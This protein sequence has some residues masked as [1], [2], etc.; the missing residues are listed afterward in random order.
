MDISNTSH[1][2][3]VLAAL[4]MLPAFFQLHA[5]E[6]AE[7]GLYLPTVD[8]AGM[9]MSKQVVSMEESRYQHVVRQHT[10]YS[11]GAASLATILKYGYGMDVDEASVMQGLLNVSD[12]QIVMSKG[13]SLLD[14]KNYAE[15]LGFRARGYR[16]TLDRLRQIRVPT[17]V[18]LDLGG[19]KHFVVLK[20]LVDGKAYI[21]DPALGNKVLTVDEFTEAWA[22]RTVFA[23]IGSGF[24]RDTALLELNESPTARHWLATNGP[25]TDSEL[26]EF[27]FGYA[28]LF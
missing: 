6:A 8:G 9:R 5:V 25:L 14:L 2:G 16:V 22:T 23:V 3:G 4:L 24:K 15:Q 27:G 21:A 26:L 1:H 20:R 17:I 18:M 19:Y 10:D 11:C 28:D 7:M 12:R 13:F